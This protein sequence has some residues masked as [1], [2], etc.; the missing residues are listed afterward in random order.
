[1][2]EKNTRLKPSMPR[3]GDLRGVTRRAREFGDKLAEAKPGR[4]FSDSA[5]VIRADRDSRF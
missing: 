5:E 2:S 3:R 1:M 4:T